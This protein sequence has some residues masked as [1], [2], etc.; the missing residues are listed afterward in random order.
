MQANH[1]KKI[2]AICKK[3]KMLFRLGQHAQLIERLNHTL[4][5]TLPLKF[6]SH[7]I[8]ANINGKTLVLHTDNASFASL[9]R[10]QVPS[11]C[12]TFSSDLDIAINHIEIKVRPKVGVATPKKKSPAPLPKTASIVLKET[13]VHIDNEA[14]RASMEKLAKRFKA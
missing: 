4:H 9:I 14:L 6:S 5:Q 2:N 1:P 8:I 7:C 13:A 12:K 11:L 3:N 10:F